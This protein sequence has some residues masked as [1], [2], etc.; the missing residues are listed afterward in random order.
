[1]VLLLVLF[2]LQ[3]ALP[4]F[5]ESRIWH[6]MALAAAPLALGFSLLAGRLFDPDHPTATPLLDKLNGLLSGRFEIW[7][8]VFWGYP[9]TTRSRTGCP[10]GT[11]MPCP[12][13]LPFWVALPLMETSTTPLITLS[14]PSR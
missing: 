14:L 9:S 1:M 3:R 7:H 13:P 10:V 4:A 5:F 12:R 6:G 2:L 8:H 11:M